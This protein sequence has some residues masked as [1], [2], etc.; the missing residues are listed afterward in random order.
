VEAVLSA[1]L[2]AS[3]DKRRGMLSKETELAFER[4]WSLQISKGEA[5]GAWNWNNLDLG[6]WEEPESM[7]YGASLAALA[8]GVA[9]SHYHTRPEIRR[10]LEALTAYLKTNQRA[11][12]LH[13]RL[14]LV[15]AS[16]QLARVIS[17]ADRESILNVI[18]HR[19]QRDGGWTIAALGPWPRHPGAPPSAGSNAYATGLVA[20]VLQ[21]AG[22]PTSNPSVSRALVWLRSHQDPKAG[23]WEA[24]SMN[25]QYASDSM[26]FHFMR[27]AATAFA[28]LALLEA[29]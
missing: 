3:E 16:T 8:V 20:F 29:R 17:E 22:I 2:L 26:P 4:M 5:K 28:T 19:Q 6:P 12:P 18:V 15:W 1:L 23:F 14:I 7:F 13:N 11:Q 24:Q 25:K 21:R 10:N 9:P 27:D